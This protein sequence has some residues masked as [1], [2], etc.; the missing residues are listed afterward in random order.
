V[1]NSVTERDRDIKEKG[2]KR[3]PMLIKREIKIIK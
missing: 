1:N 2:N 3:E